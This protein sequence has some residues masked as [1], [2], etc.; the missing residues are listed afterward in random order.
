MQEQWTD[1]HS[2]DGGG[3]ENPPAARVQLSGTR[4]SSSPG[5]PVTSVMLGAQRSA[6]WPAQPCPQRA[7]RRPQRGAGGEGGAEGSGQ[8]GRAARR[9]EQG[10]SA[11]RPPGALCR[12]RRES[13]GL[14][15]F[16]R[17]FQLDKQ[18]GTGLHQACPA[19]KACIEGT[20]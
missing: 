11:A 14:R 16:I 12:G 7:G 8:P 2:K 5:P 4:R 6:A 1:T 17:S 10:L 19:L 20:N 15:I 9:R 18:V 13:T 3:S